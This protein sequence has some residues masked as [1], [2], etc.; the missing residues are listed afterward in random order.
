VAADPGTARRNTVL[1]G[2]DERALASL[3]PDLGETPLPSGLVLHEAGQ[4]IR[5]VY[6]PLVGVV[7][8]VADLGDDQV[9]ETATVGREGMVGVSVYLGSDAPTERALVQVPGR[10][11][12]MTA[13]DFREHIADVDGPLAAM[14]RPRR[15]R[16]SPRCR[17][18]P[19]ATG[20]TP[21]ASEPPAGC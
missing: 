20:C 6:F 7:S 3:L 11:L 5:D 9:V 21:S 15:R 12:T 18:T 1:A 10:A 16:C 17:A 8:I 2:L 14:L 19:P 13:E 4:A